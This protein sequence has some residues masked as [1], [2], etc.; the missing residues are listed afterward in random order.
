MDTKT[1]QH[2]A[3][4]LT[5]DYSYYLAWHNGIAAGWNHDN[6]GGPL[7]T[8]DRGPYPLNDVSDEFGTAMIRDLTETSEGSVTLETSVSFLEGFDGCYVQFRDRDDKICYGLY[9]DQGSIYLLLADGTGKLLVEHASDVKRHYIKTTLDFERNTATTI[10]D[11]ISYGESTLLSDHIKTYRLGTTEK[12]KLHIEP[13]VTLIYCNYEVNEAF[14]MPPANGSAIPCDWTSNSGKDHAYLAIDRDEMVLRSSNN[15]SVR[16]QKMFRPLDGTLC[17]ET[18]FFLPKIADGAAFS[19]NCG[20][21]TAFKFCTVGNCFYANNKMLREYQAEMWYRLRVEVDLKEQKALVKVNGKHLAQVDLFNQPSQIDHLVISLTSETGAEM[22][23]DDVRVFSLVEH[24]DYVPQP[25]APHKKDYAV[26]MNVCPL[27]RTGSHI[28]W[29]C[30]SPYDEIKP[31]IGY[32]DEGL[33]ETADWEIKFFVEHGIDFQSFCWYSSESNAPIKKTGLSAAI[34]DGYFNAKYSDQMKFCLLWEAANAAHPAGSE[35]FR[36]YFVPYWVEQFFTDSRYMTIDNKAVI[37][38]FGVWQIIKD[39]GGEAGVK[40]EF[41]YLRGV[42]KGL[43]YDGAILLCCCGSGDIPTLTTVKNCGFDAVQA[44]NW[45]H[46]GYSVEFTEKAIYTQ[47]EKNVIHVVPTA[48]TGFNN[49]AWAGTRYPN[50]SVEDFHKLNLWIR[51]EILAGFQK[52][53]EPWKHKLMMLSNWNEYGE[54]TYLMPSGLNGFGY[55]DCL[56]KIYTE[57]DVPHVD[58]VPN[59]AQLQRICRMFPSDRSTIR[60]LR[61]YDFPVPQS[62]LYRLQFKAEPDLALWRLDE[63]DAAIENGML[64]GKSLGPDPKIIMTQDANFDITSAEMARLKMKASKAGTV[65]IFFTTKEKPDW[66]Q[67]QSFRASFQE[68]ENELNIR[69]HSADWTGELKRLRIDP[70]S[71]AGVEFEI[72]SLEFLY[73]PNKPV[74]TINGRELALDVMPVTDHG[75]HM[76]PFN[77]ETAI[78]Y[79]LNAYYRWNRSKGLLTI[80][81]NH[82]SCTFKMGDRQALING[83]QMTLPCTPDLC[84][85]LPMLPVEVMAD[86]FHYE[87]TIDGPKVHITTPFAS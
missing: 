74:Y 3:Y 72:E 33:P 75:V 57:D 65:E 53:A 50:I 86:A 63:A 24:S 39:F 78:E 4:Y 40:A 23:F 58:H 70:A 48:S 28:G 18:M 87:V 83:N 13:G 31:V 64:K 82:G 21:N 56:R 76:I 51:D 41:D 55:L 1:K 59:E 66:S 10:I 29:D 25:V 9:T 62:V 2:D 38:V 35:A 32:Y 46:E 19:L 34:H 81:A 67:S 30:I 61:Y 84:D 8:T 43:G 36:K 42:L 85:G 68:G 45:G 47:M 26:G 16:M 73:D 80:E 37:S 20:D 17:Y 15:E 12:A 79:L 5:E 60:P 44:Y 22:R 69:I 7:K 27:W 52:E 49:V 11:S 54:G 6:R 14:L 71:T 77:P